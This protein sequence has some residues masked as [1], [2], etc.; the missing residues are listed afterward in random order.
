[1]ASKALN[2]SG[3]AAYGLIAKC[4]ILTVGV[5]MIL[6]QLGIAETLVDTAFRLILAAVAIAFAIA[7]GVGG[8][9]FASRALKKLEDNMD[10]KNGEEE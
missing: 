9:D 4:A 2:K 10:K 3:H 6:M 7:F 1:M 5:F 8:R